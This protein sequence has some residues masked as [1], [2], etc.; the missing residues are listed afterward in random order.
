MI[1]RRF[2]LVKIF[3][4]VNLQILFL[5]YV[6][7]FDKVWHIFSLQRMSVSTDLPKIWMKEKQ[8]LEDIMTTQL[9]E[10][11]KKVEI[12]YKIKKVSIRFKRRLYEIWK[13]FSVEFVVDKS[14]FTIDSI[15]C[16]NREISGDFQTCWQDLNITIW[17]NFFKRSFYQQ[18]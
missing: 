8:R 9:K 5:F 13:S 7:L 15:I 2:Y 12:N 14:E 18:R 17:M 1:A 11:T 10:W 3:R 16:S 6:S 4:I